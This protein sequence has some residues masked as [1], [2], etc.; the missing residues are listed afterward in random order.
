MRPIFSFICLFVLLVS[1]KNQDKLTFE[2]FILHGDACVDCPEVSVSYPKALENTKLASTINT[3]LEEET[4]SILNFDEDITASTPEEA[5]R[6]FKNGYLELK[7]LYSD[8]TIGWEAKIEGKV[9]YEDNA[10]LTVELD[11]YIFTG[12][13]HGYS[14]KQFLNF[15][16]TKGKELENRQLFIN[17][18]EFERFA[19]IK[20]REQEKIPMDKSINHTGFMFEKDSFHLPENI[21]FTE[22][23]IQLRYNPYEVASYAD[24]PLELTLPYDEVKKFLARR[25]KS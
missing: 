10:L 8:E 9:I 3:A 4:I 5:I 13:A 1:C 20:F 16:K 25:G 11:S 2:P 24:G 23:G 22:K 6:S 14:S 12:G 18:D 19:E 21:G 15:D 7:R 17:Q